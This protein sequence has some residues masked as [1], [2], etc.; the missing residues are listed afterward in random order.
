MHFVPE[1]LTIVFD[2]STLASYDETDNT[3]PLNVY[4]KTKLD[5]EN[6]ILSIMELNAIIIRTSWV[7]SEHGNNFVNTILI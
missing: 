7:Y 5:G 3:S 6:A 4:G 2:G 1:R